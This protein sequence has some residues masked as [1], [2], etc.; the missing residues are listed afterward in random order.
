MDLQSIKRNS[1]DPMDP[2]LTQFPQCQHLM[3]PAHST[4]QISPCLV[5][6]GWGHVTA[7]KA[8]ILST[9]SAVPSLTH[10]PFS[11]GPRG[12]GLTPGHPGEPPC[13]AVVRL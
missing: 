5:T 8:V 6:A 4:H 10:G 3:K 11:L 13:T 7:A 2:P 12:H 9:G 1:T